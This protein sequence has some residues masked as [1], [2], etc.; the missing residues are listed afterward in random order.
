[1]ST[2]QSLP[3]PR[4][5]RLARPSWR[6][7]RLLGGL[8]LVLLAVGGTARVV[9]AADH[10]VTVYAA[11][12]AL[13]PG[14]QLAAG[15]I[16]ATR[17]NIAGGSGGYLRVDAGLDEGAVVVASV[18]AGQLVPE[19]AVGSASDVLVRALTIPVERSSALVLARGDRVDV[20]VAEHAP[21]ADARAGT[22]TFQDPRRL[23]DDVS[24]ASV[25]DTRPGLGAVGSGVGVQVLVPEDAVAAVLKHIH[26]ESRLTLVPVAG[27]A[28]GGRR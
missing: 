12:E 2:P 6:D 22:E 28:V 1:M 9:Q 8:V 14:Q 3:M 27:T 16:V 26:A 13:V 18:G 7:P 21:S 4:A 15:D 25:P 23:L 11:R 24:V 10:S 20:W 17:V 5:R 19:V